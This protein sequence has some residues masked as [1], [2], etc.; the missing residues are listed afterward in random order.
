MKRTVRNFK[1][2]LDRTV[3]TLSGCP[4][5]LV[6]WVPACVHWDGAADTGSLAVLPLGSPLSGTLTRSPRGPHP[7]RPVVFVI[8]VIV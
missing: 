8:V 2:E 5:V 1:E 7:S 4:A 6:P 3:Q